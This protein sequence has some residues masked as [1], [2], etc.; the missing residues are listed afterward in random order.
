[1]RP[2]QALW[3]DGDD[4]MVVDQTQLPFTYGTRRLSTSAEAIAAIRAM[5]V[6]GAGVIGNVG[7]FGVYFAVRETQGCWDTVQSLL[8]PLRAARPTA[9]N[10]AWAVDRMTQV[11]SSDPAS[12][13]PLIQRARQEAI[14]IVEEDIERSRR[15]GEEGVALITAISR[16]KNGQPVEILTHCNAGAMAIV[17]SGSALAPI[18]T[19]HQQGIPVH[20]WVDETRPRNQGAGITTWE[21]AQAGIPHT[22]IVDNAGGLLMHYGKVDLCIVGADRVT[23]TGDVINKIGTYLKALAA[24]AHGV[25]FY[26]A[27][28]WSTLDFSCLDALREVEIETRSPDEVLWVTGQDDSGA[29]TR[30]RIAPT[31]TPALNYGFDITPH[32]LI[33]GYITERGVFSSGAIA[34]LAP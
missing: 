34:H 9:V 29:I 17:D 21:L 1:M 27:L 28:P 25:P 22:L 30:V 32:S 12:G 24:A 33:T 13:D 20:V 19:A 10:L 6:R 7:A 5:T 2:C 3:L 11:L 4:L 14:L 18:Y 23:A 26:V 31:E 8:P 16:Q 15:I